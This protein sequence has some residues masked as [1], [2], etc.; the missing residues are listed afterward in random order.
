MQNFKPRGTFSADVAPLTCHRRRRHAVRGAV[1]L[2]QVLLEQGEADAFHVSSSGRTALME[3]VAHGHERAVVALIRHGQA[4][5][6][7]AGEHTT[8][9][10]APHLTLWPPAHHAKPPGQQDGG[11]LEQALQGITHHHSNA[12][13]ALQ[14]PSGNHALLDATAAGHLSI[15]KLLVANG[16]KVNM[17]DREGNTALL[18]AAR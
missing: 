17:T 5:P 11:V 14:L 12:D 10:A 8:Q 13:W 3:A 1:L 15:L 2:E 18:L 7:Q 4:D 16:A 9:P 6:R